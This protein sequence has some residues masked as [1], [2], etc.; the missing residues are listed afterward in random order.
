MR[1]SQKESKMT[2]KPS[3]FVTRNTDD[4]LNELK[5]F[6]EK[7]KQRRESLVH[8]P[9][10][11][12]KRSQDE[13]HQNPIYVWN[14]KPV[15]KLIEL[16]KP[17]DYRADVFDLIEMHLLKLKRILI[18]H[19]DEDSKLKLKIISN[20]VTD[21]ELKRQLHQVIASFEDYSIRK[22]TQLSTEPSRESLSKKSIPDLNFEEQF[23]KEIVSSRYAINALSLHLQEVIGLV[24]VLNRPLLAFIQVDD[25]TRRWCV[26]S[27]LDPEQ[28]MPL[29]IVNGDARAFLC[30]AD[31][32]VKGFGSAKDFF[33]YLKSRYPDLTSATDKTLHQQIVNIFRRH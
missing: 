23:L 24:K 27:P 18:Y 11:K 14:T 33:A 28:I 29:E 10:K 2:S 5:T 7:E 16:L 32:R 20:N 1:G 8:N 13:F 6:S 30:E 12:T 15:Q 21:K 26:I 17:Y 31:D 9:L 25:D 19:L 4:V 22:K 3:G